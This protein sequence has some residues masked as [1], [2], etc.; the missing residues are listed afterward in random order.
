MSN[1][2]TAI[3]NSPQVLDLHKWLLSQL[4]WRLSISRSEAP[5]PLLNGRAWNCW[6]PDDTRSFRLDGLEMLYM[7][8]WDG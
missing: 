5:Y 8:E 4:F 3:A 2:G 1:S 7:L 6:N